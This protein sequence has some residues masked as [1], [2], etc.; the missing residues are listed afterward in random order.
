MLHYLDNATNT[1]GRTMGPVEQRM[2]AAYINRT[3]ATGQRPPRA[4]K[5]P[6]SCPSRKRPRH[7]RELRAGDQGAPYTWRRRGIHPERRAGSR[8]LL[9]RLD[10]RPAAHGRRLSSARASTTT[11]PKVVLGH[12]IPAGGRV[13]QDG[14][15]PFSTFSSSSPALRTSSSGAGNVRALR[16]RRSAPP[17]WSTASPASSRRKRQGDLRVRDRGDPDQPGNSL[18]VGR[19]ATQRSSRHWNSRSPPCA[20]RNRPSLTQRSRAIRG[21]LRAGRMEGAAVLGREKAADRIAKRQ[22]AIAQLARRMSWANPSSPAHR[23]PATRSN[24]QDLGQPGALIERLNFAMA[25]DR[26]G[27]RR[28]PP[29]TPR[30]CPARPRSRPARRRPRPMRRPPAAQTNITDATRKVLDRRN[31]VAHARPAGRR[32]T[33]PSSSPSSSVRPNSKENSHYERQSPHLPQAGRLS[34]FVCMGGPVLRG[35]AFLRQAPSPP[36]SA[37][38]QLRQQDPDL[39]LPARRRGWAS[40]WSSPTAIRFYY[41]N[42][43]PRSASARHPR[44]RAPMPA[45]DLDG[46]FAPAPLRSLAL[47]PALPSRATLRRYPGLRIAQCLA[48]AFRIAGS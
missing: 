34:P 42:R 32:S 26:A 12:E 46:Y 22:A 25:L 28:R 13:I 6:T 8:A 35:R 39:H 31:G 36:I 29:S 38:Q 16:R 3:F 9:H 30:R 17:P 37:L 43:A 40:R 21:K 20:R 10:L 14:E 5:S 45:L 15:K 11:A 33:P 1:V 23:R 19:L 44:P 24:L 27:G 47:L 2:R 48:L 18:A 4:R 7:Q 41:Q